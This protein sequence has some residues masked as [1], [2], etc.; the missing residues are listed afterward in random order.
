MI[1]L[2]SLVTTVKDYVEITHKLL[3]SDSSWRE[4]ISQTYFDLGALLTYLVLTLKGFFL[5]FITFNWV[6]KIWSLPIVIPEL[7]KSM[8]SEIS[9]LD[10]YYHNSLTFLDTPLYQHNIFLIRCLEKFFIGLLNSFFL[11]LPTSIA[12]IISIRRFATQ[13]T[14]AGYVSSLGT[15]IGNTLWF[16]SILFGWRFFVIPWLTFDVLRYL[17]GFMLLINYCADTYKE[18]QLT[19]VNISKP[20]VFMLNFILSFTEQTNIYPYVGNLSFTSDTSILENIGTKSVF[21]FFTIHT[22]YLSGIVAGCLLLLRGC[23]WFWDNPGFRIYQSITTRYK[24]T[25]AHYNKILNI[26][27]LYITV[28]CTFSSAVYFG[29]DSALLSGLGYVPDDRI[30]DQRLV[31]ETNYAYSKS[32]D[33]NTRKKPGR[34]CRR[35][36]WKQRTKKHYA[37]DV[38]PYESPMNDIFTLE[39]LNYGFERFWARRKMKNH[40]IRYR[41]LPGK[42]MKSIKKKLARPKSNW[43]NLYRFDFFRMINENA[44]TD[45]FH[46]KNVKENTSGKD[47]SLLT[48]SLLLND[49]NN[50]FNYGSKSINVENSV[51]RKFVRKIQNRISIGKISGFE[52]LK[53]SSYMKRTPIYKSK[54]SP[55]YGTYMTQKDHSYVNMLLNKTQAQILKSRDGPVM[56]TQKLRLSNIDKA[57]LRY[58]TFLLN[59]NNKT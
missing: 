59:A 27:F 11:F 54:Y 9:V 5:D 55:V 50:P 25:T 52:S 53:N 28:F 23:C 32:S 57:I 36:R 4:S 31:T 10:G 6:H 47:S 29:I 30:V 24:M 37:L 16:A 39:D 43:L 45:R 49:N 17:L 40:A 8:I 34:H 46:S 14:E 2:I 3:E 1:T 41:V 15:I 22:F 35:E 33:R 7:T 44:Y 26:F 38:S 13:G 56:E 12:H 51:L 42:I 20:Q 21:G 58:R 18:R 48:Y 19:V